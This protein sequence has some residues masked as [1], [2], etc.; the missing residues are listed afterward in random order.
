MYDPGRIALR[1]HSEVVE[2]RGHLLEPKTAPL[3]GERAPLLAGRP[4]SAPGFLLRARPRELRSKFPH[5]LVAFETQDLSFDDRA[6]VH[7]EVH[8]FR[9]RT[10]RAVLAPVPFAQARV[11]R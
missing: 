2:S 7:D 1:V 9:R 11:K 10:H 4:R 3:R 8:A 5:R 6:G